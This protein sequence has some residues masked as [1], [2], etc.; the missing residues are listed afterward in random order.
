MHV[1]WGAKRSAHAHPPQHTHTH[2]QFGAN[3]ENSHSF[4]QS[5]NIPPPC[6][7]MLCSLFISIWHWCWFDIGLVSIG[8]QRDSYKEQVQTKRATTTKKSDD[9]EPPLAIH[10]DIHSVYPM[11]IVIIV[12]I[13]DGC[14]CCSFFPPSSLSL[15]HSLH[16]NSFILECSL[17]SHEQPI[18]YK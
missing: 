6:V 17:C 11:N 2:N 9:S 1:I 12:I 10:I 8:A 14:C 15:S 7:Q 5:L 13:C 3:G 18:K 4:N 16:I